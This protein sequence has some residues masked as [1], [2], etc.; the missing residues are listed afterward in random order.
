MPITA[1]VIPT[2]LD[3]IL[4]NIQQHLMS[5]LS[6]VQQRVDIMDPDKL[7][8]NKHPLG[9]NYLVLWPDVET[10]NIPIFQGAGRLDTR[11]TDRLNV[12]VR[13]AAALDEYASAQTWLTDPSLGHIFLRHQV[14]DALLNYLPTDSNSNLLTVNGLVPAPAR[15]AK[16]EGE[17]KYWGES[18]LAFDVNYVL[19]LTMP[20]Y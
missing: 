18:V 9:S 6:W 15:K 1:T 11:M 2:R 10:P 13:S 14:W 16:L 4:L 8:V 5:S 19:A 3:I 12:H 7:P 20:P 17:K